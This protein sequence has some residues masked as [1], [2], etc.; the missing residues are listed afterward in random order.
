M[1]RTEQNRLSNIFK[2]AQHFDS[3][4][5]TRPA[6]WRA[7]KACGQNNAKEETLITIEQEEESTTTTATRMKRI[8]SEEWTV[9]IV[10]QQ[11]K[12]RAPS[13]HIQF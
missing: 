10:P 6:G 13:Q 8:K 2:Q 9:L 12:Q 1:N 7:C 11:K 3:P 5:I 4:F